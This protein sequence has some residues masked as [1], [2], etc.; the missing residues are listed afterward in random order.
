MTDFLIS[1]WEGILQAAKS[2][3]S[4]WLLILFAVGPLFAFAYAVEYWNRKNL[5][6]NKIMAW[7]KT[8]IKKVFRVCLFFSFAGVALGCGSLV[9]VWII[10]SF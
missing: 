5:S 2:A 6:V 7:I 1:L 10:R 9:I 3:L 8:G 4:L